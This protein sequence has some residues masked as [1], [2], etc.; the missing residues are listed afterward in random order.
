VD[1]KAFR[2]TTTG[3]EDGFTLIELLVVMLV[4]GIL[5]AIALPAFFNQRNKASDAEAKQVAH[6]AHVA[7]ETCNSDNKGVYSTTSCNLAGLRTIVPTLPSAASEITVQPNSPASGFTIKVTAASKNTFSI[8]RSAT[9]AL[10]YACT[11]KSSN[12]GGCPGSGTAGG[13]WGP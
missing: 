9:G 10:T 11:V 4:L 7:M 6:T 13:V 12:R 5:T 1:V 3:P 8:S 2:P